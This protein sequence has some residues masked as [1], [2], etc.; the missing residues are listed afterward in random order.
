MEIV[1]QASLFVGVDFVDGEKEWLAPAKEKPRQFYVRGSEF[2][3]R[4]N[5][6]DHC[7]GFFKSNL[8]LTKNFGWDELF[9]VGEDAPRIYDAK[10]TSA[11]LCLSVEPVTGNSRFV[12]DNSAARSDQPIE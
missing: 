1:Y 2:T 9:V 6:Q 10:G 3:A 7:I 5:Y 11:P 8:R 4:V 12:A